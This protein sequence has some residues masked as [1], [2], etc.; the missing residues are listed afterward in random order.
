MAAPQSIRHL[1]DSLVYSVGGPLAPWRPLLIPCTTA[2]IISSLC[3][4]LHARGPVHYPARAKIPDAYTDGQCDT[5]AFYCHPVSR[6][7]PLSASGRIPSMTPP[8]LSSPARSAPYTVRDNTSATRK[9]KFYCLSHGS[10]HAF[11]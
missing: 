8:L 3:H 5:L 6:R 9:R 11:P 7:R 1:A 10:A 4:P 2:E